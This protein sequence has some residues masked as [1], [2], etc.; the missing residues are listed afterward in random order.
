MKADGGD[1]CDA[2][3]LDEVGHVT[4]IGILQWTRGFETMR[5]TRTYSTSHVPEM[6]DRTQS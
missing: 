3:S 5:T 6:S 1:P 4:R 2:Y